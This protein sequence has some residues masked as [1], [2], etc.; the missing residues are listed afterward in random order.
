[1]DR[2]SGSGVFARDPDALL[3]LIELEPTDALLKQEEN[4]AICEVC[5]D[6]LKNCN[7]LGE[8]SQDDMCSSVQML[9][10]CRENLK[11]LEFKVLNVKVQEAVDRVHVRSAWRIEGT[12]RE[13]PKF[14]PVNVWFDYPIHKIDESGALK[15]IQPD[16]DKPSWQRGSVNNKKN[17]QSRKEDRK[18]ALQE[19]V[20]GCNFGEIPTVKDVAEYLGISERTV[21]DRIKEHG[22]YTIQ[23]GK[24]VKKAS[25]RSAGKTEIQASP[26]TNGYSSCGGKDRKCRLPRKGTNVCNVAGKTLFQTSPQK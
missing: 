15:D 13:F 16:D 18:K 7:K 5:I 22:G 20:E 4:K 14:Q 25:R 21:R 6:Y 12:L 26:H 24:V 10:Y 1:M 3:D 11:S 19:A 23:D 9:D 8:V 2:A 17:A